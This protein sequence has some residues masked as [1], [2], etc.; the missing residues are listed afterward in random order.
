M[1]RNFQKQADDIF[2]VVDK[3]ESRDYL[4][5]KYRHTPFLQERL[6]FIDEN[7]N[8]KSFI[9]NF[10]EINYAK[11]IAK[12]ESLRARERLA[13]KYGGE[14]DK[15]EKKVDRIDSK[16]YMY[17]VHWYEYDNKQYLMKAKIRK[18]RKS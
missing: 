2:K 12:G 14:P 10:A 11:T 18:E 17:D 1:R 4:L 6:D 8:E 3:T 9:P 13:R 7:T 5:L 15:W 16:K